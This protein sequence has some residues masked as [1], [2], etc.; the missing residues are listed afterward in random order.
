MGM[1]HQFGTIPDEEENQGI[2]LEVTDIPSEWLNTRAAEGDIAERYNSGALFPLANIV[3]FNKVTN[4]K[5]IGRL[6]TSKRVFEAVVAIPFYF[7]SGRSKRSIEDRIF[8]ERNYF[9]LSSTKGDIENE[10]EEMRAFAKNIEDMDPKSIFGEDQLSLIN[11]SFKIRDKYVFP[12]EFDYFRN[13]ATEPVAM[14][15]FEFDHV[16]DKDDLSYIWQ[17][18]APKF[19]TNKTT[20]EYFEDIEDDAKM[21]ASTVSHPLFTEG[22]EQLDD[23]Q[24][25]GKEQLDDLQ[26]PN[27]EPVQWIVFKVKQRAKTSYSKLLIPNK[28]EKTPVSENQFSYN[29]P[30]DYFSMIEFAK[31][32]SKIS[33]GSVEIETSAAA[34]RGLYTVESSTGLPPVL[35]SDLEQAN[36][37]STSEAKT[38]A[39]L[40]SVEVSAAALKNSKK[41]K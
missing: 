11:T 41:I 8:P 14:Y 38:K 31:I 3:G 28:D 6:A 23:L 7:A 27:G 13:Q 18:I 5:K 20:P 37:T 2:F 25:E 24:A 26:G 29:W 32:D 33:Y 34:K 16:F 39:Q 40:I 21:V 9:K 19:G 10:L 4:S 30:Y 35:N 1:W 17:N 12:P 15:I 36:S 22:K